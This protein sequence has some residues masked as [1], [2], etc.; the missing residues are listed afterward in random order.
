VVVKPEAV[1]KNA[2]VKLF[3]E[4]VKRKGK[5]P[6]RDIITHAKVTVR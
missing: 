2:S 4:F 5:V 3:M 1:S 6:N